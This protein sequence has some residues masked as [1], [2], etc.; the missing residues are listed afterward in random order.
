MKRSILKLC[1][2]LVVMLFFAACTQDKHAHTESA[3][4]TCPMHPQVVSDAPGS[5]PVC[6]MDLVL[7]TDKGVGNELMLSERQAQLA[8]VRTMKVGSGSF[9]ASKLLNGR[10]L[11]N[12]EQ[13]T[14]VSSRYSGRIEK[15]F[16]KETGKVLSAGDPI[17]QIYSEPL[18]ALQ[19]DYLL[20]HKQSRAFPEEKI[21]KDLLKSAAN[22]LQ[23]YGYTAAQLNALAKSDRP[24][25]TITVFARESGVVNE[26][27]VT[28]GGYVDEGS[29][30]LQLENFN[31]LW[32]EAD[33][34]PSEAGAVKE[35]TLV[36]VAVNGLGE[37]RSMR[38]QYVAPQIAAG[39]QILTIRGTI[40][41]SKG[42]L[43]PGMQA[44]VLLG[45]ASV[46]NAVRL[47]L[48]AVI[49]KE[50]G[51]H[52]WIKTGKGTFAPRN[53]TTGAEDF[54]QIVVTSGLK[55]GDEVVVSGGYL[56][57]SEFVLK[58][59]TDPTLVNNH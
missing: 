46:S 59:G 58:K 49:R 47:P 18:Q 9:T 45:S 5:C 40:D 16:V 23:L 52:V 38:V 12:P 41:N 20:Q 17:F 44:T 53:I 56:L 19:Q 26:I 30:V 1:G 32:V 51:S 4:Y 35:G 21:Y 13:R 33:V 29:P 27:S 36:K 2:M 50:S 55:D 6:G 42:D 57:Y 37:Q 43:Q 15:L 48:D 7:S 28:E 31:S 8:N 11:A 34:Y 10:L 24:S 54:E 3:K 22:R 25:P 39:S 14:V